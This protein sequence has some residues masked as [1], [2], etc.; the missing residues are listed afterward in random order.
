MSPTTG[1]QRK[2]QRQSTSPTAATIA[3]PTS[4]T[5]ST[6]NQGITKNLNTSIV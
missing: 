6:S 4:T 5:L 3:S 1:Q 2:K